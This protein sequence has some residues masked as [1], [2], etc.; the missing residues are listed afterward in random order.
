MKYMAGQRGQVL[1]ILLGYLFLG[2]AATSIT[3]F[4]KGNSPRDLV[5]RVETVV[6]DKMRQGDIVTLI[7]NWEKAHDTFQKQVK[8]EREVLLERLTSYSATKQ[9]AMRAA[10]KLNLYID[11]DDQSFLD[12]RFKMKAQL[13][14][15]EWNKIWASKTE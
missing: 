9:D 10:D 13:S 3:T 15:D 11:E 4:V 12:L 14:R 8:K 5:K 7:D 1:I 6:S 2:G